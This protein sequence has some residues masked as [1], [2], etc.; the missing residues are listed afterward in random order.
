MKG[1]DWKGGFSY[2]GTL[3]VGFSEESWDRR[4]RLDA[5]MALRGGLIVEG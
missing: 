5:C 4:G 1:W 2:C 3:R